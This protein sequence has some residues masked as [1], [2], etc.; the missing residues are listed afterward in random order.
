MDGDDDEIV[1]KIR[2][3]EKRKK[4]REKKKKTKYRNADSDYS[5]SNTG[6]TQDIRIGC[7]L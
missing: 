3:D 5:C 1:C 4:K 7:E 6:I 2:L